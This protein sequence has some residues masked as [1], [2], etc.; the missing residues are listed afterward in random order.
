M[1]E[2]EDNR[3]VDYLY[4]EMDP[5]ERQAFQEDMEA[6]QALAKTVEE[7]QSMLGSLRALEVEE[8]PSDHLDSLILAQAKQTI[9]SQEESWI[10]KLF[11]RPGLALAFSGAFALVIAVIVLPN[12]QTQAPVNDFS[13]VEVT[14]QPQQSAS[15]KAPNTSPPPKNDTIVTRA[16]EEAPPQVARKAIKTE[17]VRRKSKQETQMR[18]TFSGKRKRAKKSQSI[19][20]GPLGAKMKNEPSP[21]GGSQDLEIAISQLGARGNKSALEIGTVGALD[22]ALSPNRSKM[23]SK[24]QGR[25]KERALPGPDPRTKRTRSL[26]LADVS[27][28]IPEDPAQREAWAR[29]QARNAQKIARKFL[30]SGDVRAARKTYLKTR[31]WVRGTVAFFEVSLWLAQLE[32]SQGRFAE[33]RQFAA[34]AGRSRDQSIQEKAREVVARVREDQSQSD[35]VPAST[36]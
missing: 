36:E 10:Q 17:Q 16:E 20:A 21:K 32:Y 30:K 25:I 33:A 3:L 29:K 23:R 6:D 15:K 18:S 27:T 14:Q 1:S 5:S 8:A 35:S 11:G 9:E 4:G 28:S 19:A 22:G 12:M 31:T 7:M 2:L 13:G 34:E 26:A 24:P